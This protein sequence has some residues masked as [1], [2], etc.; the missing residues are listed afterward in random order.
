MTKY[1]VSIESKHSCTG[2]VDQI[3]SRIATPVSSY[4]LGVLC[5]NS[6]NQVEDS[7]PILIGLSLLMVVEI[8]VV[9]L[10]KGAL[11]KDRK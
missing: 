7:Q 9:L 5:T 6:K 10:H 8:S 2:K 3:I 1:S 11:S 4:Y